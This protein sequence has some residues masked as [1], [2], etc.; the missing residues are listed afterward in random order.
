M[1]EVEV[2]LGVEV[3]ERALVDGDVVLHVVDVV[4]PGWVLEGDAAEPLEPSK[5]HHL[6]EHGAA[7]QEHHVC[8]PCA[9]HAHH[10]VRRVDEPRKVWHVG[11][12]VWL[13]DAHVELG[14]G[15]GV[16]HGALVEEPARALARDDEQARA[17]SPRRARAG[18]DGALETECAAEQALE[19]GD[20]LGA[21]GSRGVDAH[22]AVEG[23]ADEDAR[24]AVHL[25][26]VVDVDDVV[27]GEL[28]EQRGELVHPPVLDAADH[29]LH[30][31]VEVVR[32][33]EERHQHVGVVVVQVAR[34]AA[35]G[36]EEARDGVVARAQRRDGR[37]VGAA[38]GEEREL[39]DLVHGHGVVTPRVRLRLPLFRQ[40]AD[41]DQRVVAVHPDVAHRRATLGALARVV[42]GGAG[43]VEILLPDRAVQ[44]VPRAV[45]VLVD[46]H[47]LK[48][49]RLG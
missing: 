19:V 29:E 17:V 21:G 26:V 25:L 18:G 31:A 13:G 20:G 11:V 49:R 47:H 45:V 24:E 28:A 6:D 23:G 3:P 38:E 2:V 16:R 35:V 34:E 39:A 41:V 10:D 22:G 9:V 7:G 42:A 43:R 48:L 37:V 36:E 27:P 40:R 46:L 32:G 8:E 15:R 4:V 12:V 14:H 44:L 5:G 30:L 33:G 1:L